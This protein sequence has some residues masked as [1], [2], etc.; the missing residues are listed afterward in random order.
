[1]LE[2]CI[3]NLDIILSCPSLVATLSLHYAKEKNTL[4]F[5]QDLNLSHL[6]TSQMLLPTKPLDLWHW[7]RGYGTYA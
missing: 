4:R 6:A 1:M 5:N 2:F 3:V 7:S